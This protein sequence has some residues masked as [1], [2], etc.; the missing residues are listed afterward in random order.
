MGDVSGTSVWPGTVLHVPHASRTVPPDVRHTLLLDDAEMDL[1]LLRM[2][3]T[4]TD[5]LFAVSEHTAVAIGCPVSRLVI[6]PERF[7][8]DAREPMA[9]RGMGAVYTRTADGRPLRDTI[10]ATERERLLTEYYDLHHRRLAEAVERA[11]DAHGHCLI[12]DC[13]SFPSVPLPCDLDSRVPRP[14]ICIGTDSFHTPRW[15]SAA[16]IDCCER[17]E[18]AV[19]VDKPYAGSI[20]PSRWYRKDPRVLSIMVEVSRTLY[21][22]EANGEKLPYFAVCAEVCQLLCN[23]LRRTAGSWL[24]ARTVP[25]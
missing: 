25:N 6:D 24:A 19:A 13:H 14:D 17:R 18:L 16:A 3:D 7:R 12:I 15:L 20:V 21:M 1:E 8:D 2:T 4:Y 22:D 23:S 9:A 11:L 10:D 5:E